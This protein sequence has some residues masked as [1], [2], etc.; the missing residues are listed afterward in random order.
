MRHNEILLDERDQVQKVLIRVMNEI[1]MILPKLS[2]VLI[3]MQNLLVVPSKEFLL[4]LLKTPMFLNGD[5][6]TDEYDEIFNL[7]EF[8][9][10]RY[11]PIKMIQKILQKK[12]FKNDDVVDEVVVHDDEV[13]E[14]EV[15]LEAD[16]DEA[17]GPEVDDEVAE[18]D[19]EMLLEH[20]DRKK[21]NV[22]MNH[23]NFLMHKNYY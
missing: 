6:Q 7:I 12:I 13:A 2:L 9:M 10:S 8:L 19:L 16:D 22:L 11:Q 1:M 5:L 15:E 14:P 4:K 23:Y 20:D 17:V 3:V 21:M 18:V